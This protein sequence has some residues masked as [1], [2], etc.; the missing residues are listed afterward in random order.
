[1][2]TIG[3]IPLG[4]SPDAGPSRF[5]GLIWGDVGSGKTPFALTA[6]PKVLYML[7]DQDGDKSIK[8][9]RHLYDPIDYTRV[10]ASNL[11]DQFFNPGTTTLKDLD[12]VLATREYKSLVFD[13]VTAFLDLALVRGI[14]LAAPKVTKG[15]KPDLIAPGLQGYGARSSIMKA[16]AMNLHAICA[17][18]NVNLIFVA[19]ARESRD[20]DGNLTD[21]MPWLPGESGVQVPKNIS[22]IWCLRQ[23]EGQRRVYIRPW[24]V[25]RLMRTRMFLN[26]DKDSAFF[27]WRFDANKWE[28]PGQIKSWLEEYDAGGQN[29]IAMPK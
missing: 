15:V 11:V 14:E 20:N 8:H 5:T 4:H 16:A 26:E 23:Y 18:H 13:S 25:Y 29:K 9:V 6:P 10:Q 7:F 2:I 24:N 22:E 28:G 12:K 17:K 21:V 27:P 1:M 19:H 3:G